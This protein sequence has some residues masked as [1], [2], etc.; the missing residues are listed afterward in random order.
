MENLHDKIKRGIITPLK[1][2]KNKISLFSEME[3]QDSL[4]TYIIQ[5]IQSNYSASVQSEEDT[6]YSV[7]LVEETQTLKD[8]AGISYEALSI[9]GSFNTNDL[10]NYQNNKEYYII[11]ITLD[12]NRLAQ[13]EDDSFIQYQSTT[14]F[15]LG[16]S[17][18]SLKEI[19][20]E[21]LIS[22]STKSNDVITK[23]IKVLPNQMMYFEEAS[24]IISAWITPNGSI[25]MEGNVHESSGYDSNPPENDAS[26]YKYIV[27]VYSEYDPL[28]DES[29]ISIDYDFTK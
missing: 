16:T 6:P 9:T 12:P 2:A 25:Y 20:P 14:Y 3:N 23:Y 1:I 15:K 4:N 10:V 18:D 22:V 11:K 29:T 19:I 26:L 13:N 8:I 24:P 21:F 17:E 5:S 28:L 7:F 27:C